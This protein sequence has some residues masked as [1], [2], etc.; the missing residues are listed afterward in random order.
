MKKMLVFCLAAMLLLAGCSA[1]SESSA[2]AQTIKAADVP[3]YYEEYTKNPQVADDRWIQEPGQ[4]MRDNKGE[5]KLKAFAPVGETYTIGSIEL[6]VREAK[7]FQY[8]PEYSLIDFYHSYTHDMEF[9]VAKLFVEI[10]N[11][12]DEPLYFAPLALLETSG[13]E[14]KLWEDDIYLEEL[15]GEIAPGKTKKGNIGYI[16]ENADIDSLSI[17]TSDVFDEKDQKQAEALQFNV[18]F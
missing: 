1:Q 6:T 18:Q 5:A 16:V 11:T 4:T 8:K 2:S 14:T 7:I 10:K 13:G 17:T 3:D 9:D 12:S 15:N